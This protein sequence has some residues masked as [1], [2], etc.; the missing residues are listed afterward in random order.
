MNNND[1]SK[2]Q[3]HWWNDRHGSAWDRVKDALSRDWEQTKADFS[4]TKG[5]ELNQNAADTVKQAT[6]ATTPPPP[7][8][9]NAKPA[10]D[11]KTAE[12]ALRY[13]HGAAS[14]YADAK[15]WDDGLE[16]KLKTEWDNLKS[17]RD[18]DSIKRYVRHGWDSAR[19]NKS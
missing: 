7:T 19:S 4:K 3:P 17:G 15:Q 14:H 16:A 2:T 5:Q 18:W 1:D 12:P 6:G 10:D 11:Y 8:V 13:G 9:P